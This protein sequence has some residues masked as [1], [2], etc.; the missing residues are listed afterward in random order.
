[1][2]EEILSPASLKANFSIPNTADYK[3][4]Q[5]LRQN[6]DSEMQSLINKVFL[7]DPSPVD[8]Y[9]IIGLSKGTIIF[10]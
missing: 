9:L 6:S 2:S 1:M 4:A 7:P 8:N 5:T 3:N 10:V